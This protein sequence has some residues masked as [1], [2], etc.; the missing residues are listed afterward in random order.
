M[1]H[2]T[3]WWLIKVILILFIMSRALTS[4]KVCCILMCLIKMKRESLRLALSWQLHCIRDTMYKCHNNL[5]NFSNDAKQQFYL[6][7]ENMTTLLNAIT[8]E[9]WTEWRVN[10]EHYLRIIF[11][12]VFTCNSKYRNHFTE[13]HSVLRIYTLKRNN[14]KNVE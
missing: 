14:T 9:L 8:F 13:F 1:F 7:I 2:V 3:C 12:N 11:N 5:L 6:S 10:S 4:N